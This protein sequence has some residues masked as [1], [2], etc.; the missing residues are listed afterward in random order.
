MSEVNWRMEFQTNTTITETHVQVNLRWD[1]SY[2]KTVPGILKCLV[3]VRNIVSLLYNNITYLMFVVGDQPDRIC[4]YHVLLT[5][6]QRTAS[7]GVVR[8]CGHDGLLGQP[9]HSLHVPLPRHGEVPRD[10]LADD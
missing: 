6:L 5:L 9:G 2:V 8:V 4:L 7:G 1:A 10:S 3:L